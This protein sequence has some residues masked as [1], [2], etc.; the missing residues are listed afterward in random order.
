MGR[1]LVLLVGA[2]S[3]AMATDGCGDQR[4]T[5]S[6]S[7]SQWGPAAIRYLG[8]TLDGP[9]HCWTVGG[10]RTDTYFLV[11]CT[12][13]DKRGRAVSLSGAHAAVSG[14]QTQYLSGSWAVTVAG[15]TAHLSCL[16]QH[17]RAPGPCRVVG[18]I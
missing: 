6:S 12:G 15:R 4:V 8:G 7:A 17:W 2:A 1:A 16:P 14:D 10:G 13:K 9:L 18:P 5:V 3:V 11:R